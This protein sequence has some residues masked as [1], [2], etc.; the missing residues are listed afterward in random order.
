[1]TGEPRLVNSGRSGISVLPPGTI[2]SLPRPTAN[3]GRYA[4]RP[5]V[6]L[7]PRA[8]SRIS[9]ERGSTEPCTA[10][11]AS[12]IRLPSRTFPRASAGAS[13]RYARHLLAAHPPVRLPRWQCITNQSPRTV[14]GSRA[15]QRHPRKDTCMTQNRLSVMKPCYSPGC[16]C[17]K[18]SRQS[19]MTFQAASR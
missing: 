13:D 10:V 19:S 14:T 3:S 16:V 6:E 7:K 18:R 11:A 8:A 2:T 5:A 15:D 4:R 1:M 12:I 9:R 17:V